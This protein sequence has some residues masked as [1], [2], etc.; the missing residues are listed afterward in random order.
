M[1]VPNC[2]VADADCDDDNYCTDD[3]CIGGQCANDANTNA[4]ND[5]DACTGAD[6]ALPASAREAR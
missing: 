1:P 4:C 6:V 3:A 2:C 5:G